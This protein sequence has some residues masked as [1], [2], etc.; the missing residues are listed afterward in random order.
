MP[1]QVGKI[2]E[3]NRGLEAEVCIGWTKDAY[4]IVKVV[5]TSPPVQKALENLRK[6]LKQE[7]HDLLLAAQED[8]RSR[9]RKPIGSA[10]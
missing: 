5:G 2:R 10:S 7:A 3:L 8:E 9:G 1:G 4:V 6:A